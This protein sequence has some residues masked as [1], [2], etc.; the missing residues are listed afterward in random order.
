M[1]VIWNSF[2]KE[3]EK[4]AVSLGLVMHGMNLLNLKDRIKQS[5]KLTT[6]NPLTRNAAN[7]LK[8]KSPYQYRFEGGKKT[9]L[10]GTTT[11]HSF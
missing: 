5:K 4:V 2:F 11:P 6:L 8:L 7:G 9:G 3:M 1:N 10:T